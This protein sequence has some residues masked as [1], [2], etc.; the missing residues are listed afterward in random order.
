[1]SKRQL[2]FVT[3]NVKKLE[4][5]IDIL[6]TGFPFQVVSRKI[7]LPEYQGDPDD[8]CRSKCREAVKVVDG[9]VIVED[10]CLCFN[11]F[12]GLPGPYIKWF[13]DKLR[14]EGLHRMLHDFEDKSCYALC[15]IALGNY[16]GRSDDSI[17]LFTGRTDGRIVI[18][19]GPEN[20]GWDTC[21]QP[22]G[23]DETY[24]EMSTE[25]KN[26]ISYRRKALEA[27]ADHFRSIDGG[28]DRL[29]IGSQVVNL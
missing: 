16:S 4:E 2:I 28:S 23:H 21:F 8:I 5:V 20:F 9:P 26:S 18:P 25:F 10:T 24:A 1:M 3:G 27:L 12:G 17:L 15:T 14:P 29:S 7:D 11:A 13:L 22:E 6:G 19:R